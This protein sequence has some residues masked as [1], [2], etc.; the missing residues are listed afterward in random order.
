MLSVAMPEVG[1]SIVRNV[2]IMR[3]GSCSAL[4]SYPNTTS[5]LAGSIIGR[6]L[7]AQ[8]IDGLKNAA[9]LVKACQSVLGKG[10]PY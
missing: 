9:V 7:P 3:S 1:R 10:A 8:L 5:E 2:F 6:S 4:P